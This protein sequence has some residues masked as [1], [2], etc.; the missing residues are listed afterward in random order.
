[1]S[2]IF[3][4]ILLAGC[5]LRARSATTRPQ[6]QPSLSNGP[7]RAVI[8][9]ADGNDIVFNFEVR[10]SR[11]KKIL[12][13]RNGDERIPVDDIRMNRDS[14]LINL[15]FFESQFRAVLV[16]QDSLQG[17]W[18]RRL[19]DGF[20]Q[21][22]FH[23]SRRQSYRFIPALPPARNISGRW[24]VGF[25]K[26]DKNN[27]ALAVGEFVQREGRLEGTFLTP[28]GDYRYLQGVVDGDSMKLSCFDGTHAYLFKAKIVN[29]SLM[30][31]GQYFAGPTYKEE[32]TARRDEGAKLPDEFSLTKLK[33]G[34]GPLDFRFR[35]LDG[36]NVSL[37]DARFR[38][39]VVLIQI[40]GSWCPNCMDE[41]R[42]LT[43]LYGR[44]K[45]MGV[46]IIGLAYERSTDFARSQTSLRSFQKRLMVGYPLLI[47]PV[48]VNDP[49][50]TEK[51]LPQLERIAGFPTTIFLD[52]K[53]R[54]QK[55]HT[56]FNGP[57]TGAHYEEQKREF[58]KLVDGLL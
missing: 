55:I 20:Q 18:V 50:K 21:I 52:R 44:Y 56:G 45:G 8:Q 51:T 4:F 24:T 33:E 19:A 36:K 5:T 7:W 34:A 6:S 47:T 37:Q 40:M 53:G 27:P 16:N 41:T 12:Y 29:D 39:K 49:Q 26:T 48:S 13:I 11:H 10:D 1:M 3:L 14:V 54:V 30:E 43:E 58:Y 31:G 32:W 38:N 15:P 22:P 42:F 28:T 25:W 57:G 46:E 9:R 23:A 17:V 35:D 2:R